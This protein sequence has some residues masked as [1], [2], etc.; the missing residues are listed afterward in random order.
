MISIPLFLNFHLAAHY[1][2]QHIT[3]ECLDFWEKFQ[4]VLV[5]GDELWLIATVKIFCPDLQGM[6]SI[7]LAGK[8]NKPSAGRSDHVLLWLLG[9][10]NGRKEVRGR[11]RVCLSECFLYAAFSPI[12]VFL[13]VYY[14]P[15]KPFPYLHPA[16]EYPW[17][18]LSTW[19][20]C[21]DLAKIP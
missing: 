13:L 20:K 21:H 14:R 2:N 17:S 11:R 6:V 16:W 12:Q 1:L 4:R 15:F 5:A 7:W 3:V 9:I 18:L 19:F 10:W 8:L